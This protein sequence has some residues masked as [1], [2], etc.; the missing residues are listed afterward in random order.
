M[1]F[2]PL[3]ALSLSMLLFCLY[4]K[5]SETH[6]TEKQQQIQRQNKA[7]IMSIRGK[8]NKYRYR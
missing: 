3:F 4:I 6:K 1:T 8:N 5:S 2:L 7:N